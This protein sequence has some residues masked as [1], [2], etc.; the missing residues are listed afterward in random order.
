LDAHA[1]SAPDPGTVRLVIFETTV[2]DPA[3]DR[4]IHEDVGP[5]LL[6]V[7]GLTRA[8]VA[9][10]VTDSAREFV[11]VTWWKG[12][13]EMEDAVQAGVVPVYQRAFAPYLGQARLFVFEPH[14]VRCDVPD[15]QLSWIGVVLPTQD[16]GEDPSLPSPGS[17]SADLVFEGRVGEGEIAVVGASSPAERLD[18][19]LDR[20]RLSLSRL[21][22]ELP[23]AVVLDIPGGKEPGAFAS[24]PPDVGP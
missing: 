21:R 15:G 22:T 10:R 8:V 20:I 2:D 16:V 12:I 5:A 1:P 4:I 14:V 9:E 19:L 6:V 11:L 18:G 24:G 3:I 23:Y 17:S 7:P 13:K